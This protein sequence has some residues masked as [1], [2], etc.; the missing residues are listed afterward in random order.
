MFRKIYISVYVISAHVLSLVL[1][2]NYILCKGHTTFNYILTV[3][4][5]RIAPVVIM[6]SH[7]GKPTAIVI[8]TAPQPTTPSWVE[9]HSKFGQLILGKIVKIVATIREI[10][11][12][13]YTKFDFGWGREESTG[14]GGL[15]WGRGRSKG[16]MS[17]SVYCWIT[18]V[19]F[20]RY[21]TAKKR[22]P[23]HRKTR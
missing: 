5:L 17:I 6:F 15:E 1:R 21:F 3:V 9:S 23:K 22:F 8:T 18:V 10:L 19:V 2:L 14:A 4:F 11:R 16:E 12:L 20:C 13:K 7:S